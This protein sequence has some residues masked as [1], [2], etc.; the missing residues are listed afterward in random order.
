[1]RYK[2]CNLFPNFGNSNSSYARSNYKCQILASVTRIRVSETWKQVTLFITHPNYWNHIE[3]SNRIANT[4]KV[5]EVA[6]NCLV[7]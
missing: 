2:K 5:F 3:I 4:N 6:N 7:S 1:M